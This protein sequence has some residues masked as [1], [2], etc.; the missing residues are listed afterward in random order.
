MKKRLDKFKV[1]ISLIV[2]NLFSNS[3]PIPI[4]NGKY[5]KKTIYRLEKT[6]PSDLARFFL[7]LNIPNLF[8]FLMMN[9]KSRDFKSKPWPSLHSSSCLLTARVLDWVLIGSDS[10][11]E[12]LLSNSLS[13]YAGRSADH[14]YIQVSRTQITLCL[15]DIIFI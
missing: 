4:L 1:C 15:L 11:N 10:I 9:K 12:R 2:S 8:L 7:N 14:F 13:A 5:K 6:N 3:L